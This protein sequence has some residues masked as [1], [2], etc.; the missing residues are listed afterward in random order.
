MA[1]KGFRYQPDVQSTLAPW[2]EKLGTTFDSV[3]A[4][5]TD[6]DR[7]LE[8]YVDEVRTDIDTAA[9]ADLV[10][11]HI[12]GTGANIATAGANWVSGQRFL[13]VM[14]SAVLNFTAGNQNIVFPSAFP[15]GL[16]S[17]V[18]SHGGGPA[19]T[20]LNTTNYSLA[21]CGIS[22]ILAGGAVT[23]LLRINYIALGW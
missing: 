3:V 6:R 5:L 14:E 11:P 23:G 10:V 19:D 20:V 15:N 8:D 9:T 16:G 1:F 7:Q 2:R 17:V 18:V 4:M 22:A 12:S 13:M 21:G